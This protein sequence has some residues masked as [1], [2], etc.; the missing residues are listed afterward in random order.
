MSVTRPEG[1]AIVSMQ[2]T[3]NKYAHESQEFIRRQSWSLVVASTV[4][5]YSF[6]AASSK[7]P[8]AP[9]NPNDT[10]ERPTIS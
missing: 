7:A 8:A 4:E 9:E 3:Y 2:R 5:A 6:F 10:D 1:V